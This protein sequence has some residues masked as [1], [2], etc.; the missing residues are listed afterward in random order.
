M[1]KMNLFWIAVT[2]WFAIAA[3]STDDSWDMGGSNS[4]N[5]STTTNS[6]D[7]N[8]ATTGS[9]ENVVNGVS[10]NGDV[11]SF[12][13]ALNKNAI[14]ESLNVDTEDD[15][16]IENTTF[17]NT[18]TITFSSSGNATVSG[19]DAGIVSITGNDVV[20]NN[21]TGKVIKYILTGE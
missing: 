11:Q 17:A 8:S 3:C 6:N 12:T 2:V 18:I 1:K 13:V 15:D 7:D 9:A 10:T 4:Q 5:S 16:Y 19:D 21:E 14:A 20:V